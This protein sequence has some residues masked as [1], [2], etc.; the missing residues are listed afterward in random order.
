[1]ARILGKKS[2]LVRL[3]PFRQSI[4]TCTGICVIFSTLAHK[5]GTRTWKE[6]FGTS[7]GWYIPHQSSI[8]SREMIR[9]SDLESVVL[10]DADLLSPPPNPK[11]GEL[12]AQAH[13]S[14]ASRPSHLER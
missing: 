14:P 10:C 13:P 2:M 11:V 5:N 12:P 4:G 9:L 6:I 7:L 8:T 1:M 3:V